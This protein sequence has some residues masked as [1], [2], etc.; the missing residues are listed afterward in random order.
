LLPP[1]FES[2]DKSLEIFDKNES[3]VREALANASDAEFI[4]WLVAEKRRSTLFTLPVSRGSIVCNESPNP[5]S[6]TVECL[7]TLVGCAA[8]EYLMGRP[9]TRRCKNFELRI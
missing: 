8:A 4:D 1:S 6:R 7:L 9:R 2:L 3:E 5:P